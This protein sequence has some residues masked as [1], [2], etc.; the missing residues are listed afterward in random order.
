ME[1]DPTVWYSSSKQ[2][3]TE[4]R[5]E[6]RKTTWP[7]QKEATAGTIGVLIVVAALTMALSVVDFSL[8]W[9]MQLVLPT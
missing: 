3:I 6:F 2:F 1:W 4:V 5:A 8:G 9:L 7:T